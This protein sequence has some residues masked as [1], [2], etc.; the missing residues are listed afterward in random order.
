M[1]R[2]PIAAALTLVFAALTMLAV[3]ALAQ[4]GQ[5]PLPPGGFRPPPATPIKPYPPVAVTPPAPLKDPAFVA[6]R[7]Q[8]A[9]IAAHKDRAALAKLVVAQDFFWLQDKN[10][11]DPHKSGIDNLAKAI[12]LDA[13]DGSGW[14]IVT[15]DANE[16]SAAELPQQKGVFCAPADPTIDPAAFEALV[17]TTG[18][19]PSQWG[20]PT[21]DGLETHAGPGPNTPVV[22]KL[23]MVMVRV[24]PDTAPPTDPNSPLFLHVATPSG[25]TGYVDAQL[26]LPLGGDQMCYVKDAGGWKIAGYA[27]GAAQ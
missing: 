15:G 8:L 7:K 19:D 1:R 22:E 27:G 4:Q 26:L 23:G 14:D 24:L 18:T 17:K 3:S 6:F 13:K 21:A 25:K 16:A 2:L 11:A 12:D 10:L 5:L 20:F 9:D